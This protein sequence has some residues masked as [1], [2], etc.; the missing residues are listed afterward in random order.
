MSDNSDTNKAIVKKF[1]AA[2]NCGDVDFVVNA[3]AEAGSI[4][5]MGN[6]LIS[7]IFTRDEVAATAGGIFDVFPDGLKFS[8]LGM[9]SESDKVAVEATSEGKHISGQIY[10]NEYHFLFEFQNGKLLK[11]KEYLD[12]ERVTDVLCGG[13]RPPA[14]T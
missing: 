9:V 12:T 1:F 14:G 7:G 13:Q 4:Q 6:T 8:I 10:S 3:Y 11:L 2:L 5:T